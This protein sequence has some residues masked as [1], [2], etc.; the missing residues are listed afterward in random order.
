MS[1]LIS[2]IVAM[3]KNRAIGKDN[4]LLWHIPEEFKHFKATTMGKPVIMGR[5]TYESLGKPLPGRA[6]IV[7][8]RTPD[9]IEGKVFAVETLD[10]A[11]SQAT[12]IALEAGQEEICII[13]GAQ[14]YEAALPLLDRI[15]LTIIDQDYEADTFF[16]DFDQS[17]WEETSSSKYPGPPPY[18]IKILDHI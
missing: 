1:I 8:S 17:Q 7:I 9:K 18:T 2:A 16:P 12:I 3:G 5:K 11:I 6:N 4:K 15:Y 14:L 13:G 10:Q